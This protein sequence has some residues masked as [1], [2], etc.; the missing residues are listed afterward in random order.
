MARLVQFVTLKVSIHY[1]FDDNAC[2]VALRNP[3]LNE[4][5]AKIGEAVNE[6]WIRSKSSTENQTEFKKSDLCAMLKLVFYDEQTEAEQQALNPDDPKKN[7][8]NWLLPA[9]ET[10]WRVVMRCV[11]E[12]LYRDADDGPKWK[13]ALSSYLEALQHPTEE[14][15]ANPFQKKTDGVAVH[16]LVKEAL[17]LYPPS[18]RVHRQFTDNTEPDKADIESCHHSPL[19]GSDP[20]IF[21]PERWQEILKEYEELC[22]KKDSAEYGKYQ[23][24]LNEV[25]MSTKP[26]D[27]K[28]YEQYLG[29]MP[30]ANVCPS[31]ET[32]KGGL[33]T[34]AFGMK[35]IA[36]LVCVLCEGL[37][38]WELEKDSFLDRANQLRS[39]REDYSQLF[40]VRNGDV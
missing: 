5:F 37:D 25:K 35:M 9:Y 14:A 4:T 22:N 30:F 36:L 27:L 12:I 31:D 8:M 24:Y 18:R 28:R 1:L 39:G 3:D 21:R 17:R 23:K 16:D 26:D 40:L 38:G 33:S 6:T 7:P 20:L 11:I 10:M 15:G 34:K 2:H 19:F 13:T 29:Y 32:V